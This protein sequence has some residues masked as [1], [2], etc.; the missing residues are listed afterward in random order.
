MMM[1]LAGFLLLLLPEMAYNTLPDITANEIIEN[2]QDRYDDIDDAVITFTQTV[3]FKVSRVEQSYSGKMYFKKKNKF[4]IET[5][6][7]VLV[8]DGKTSWSYTPRNKQVVIDNFEEE[9]NSLSP[10]RLLF[11]LPKDYYAAYVGERKLGQVDTYVLKFTPKQ[12]GSFAVS[13]KVWINHD[14]LI[15]Q[16]EVVDI[17]GTTTT[18]FI[19]R[20]TLDQGIKDSR[21]SFTVPQGVEVIDLR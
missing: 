20:I 9:K 12:S 1:Y 10:Q 7:R 5:D 21:F 8:T 17:N 16:V 15:R 6:E 2:V 14:W 3:R 11:S 13:I 18:Y 19:K 4:R